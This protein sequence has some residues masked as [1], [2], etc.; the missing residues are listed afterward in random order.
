MSRPSDM[1]SPVSRSSRG[2]KDVNNRLHTL[3]GEHFRRTL[4]A[5]RTPR[6]GL[7]PAGFSI[8]RAVGPSLPYAEIY[9]SKPHRSSS[10]ALGV[11]VK[12]TH[13]TAAGPVPRSWAVAAAA[14]AAPVKVSESPAWRRTALS[15][16]FAQSHDD[17][18]APAPN[19]EIPESALAT[20]TTTTTG[21]GGGRGR[22]RGRPCLVPSLAEYCLRVLLEHCGHG[23]GH[24]TDADADV[25]VDEVEVEVLA[26]YLAPHHRK[27]AVRLCAVQSPLSGAALRAMIGG[28][29]GRDHHL[30]G[31]LV[32][33]EPPSSLSS[34]RMELFF[35][36][37]SA[38]HTRAEQSLKHDRHGRQWDDNDNDDADAEAEA[39]DSGWMM[40]AGGVQRGEDLEEE[41][42]E[43]EEEDEQQPLTAVAIV[44]AT[45][46][47]SALLALPPSLTRLALV[48]LSAPIPVHRLP[49]KCPLLDFLDVSYN[50]WLAEPAWGE[51][52]AL[53][54]VVWGKWAY[55][56][57]L[58]CR[59]CG[60][61]SE[62]LRRVNKGR[63]EDVMIIT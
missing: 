41:E 34:S 62:E 26:R 29:H 25:D 43:E 46:S 40:E 53:E 45:L 12:V 50:P 39:S 49:D 56:K 13:T 1:R 8:P 24:S 47:I 27:L 23:L 6:R 19:V 51:E 54:R 52:R 9:G 28:G 63:W 10:L 5:Q 21:G 42:E 37:A 55:L 48:H 44:S 2:S 59:D 3:R 22:G 31:E 7:G 11:D 33:V 15:L 36:S 35:R 30:E 61:T 14:A 17:G 4:N 18:P 32:L 20:A 57:V 16:F 60:I 58:G 38:R